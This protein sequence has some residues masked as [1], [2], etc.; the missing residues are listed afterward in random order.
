MH[1]LT[2][3]WGLVLS[4]INFHESE[5]FVSIFHFCNGHAMGN[6]NFYLPITWQ[7]VLGENL[8]KPR[9]FQCCCNIFSFW[10]TCKIG[11][12]SVCFLRLIVIRHSFCS[13]FPQGQHHRTVQIAVKFPQSNNEMLSKFEGFFHMLGTYMYLKKH[14]QISLILFSQR[15]AVQGPRRRNET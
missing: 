9:P 11:F 6:L 7:S 12:N 10:S 15:F 4:S 3:Q 1:I 13:I 14:S 5:W 2:P 8:F